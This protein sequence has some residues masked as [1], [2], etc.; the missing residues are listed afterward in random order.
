MIPAFYNEIYDAEQEERREELARERRTLRNESNP[1]ELPDEEFRKMYRLTKELAQNLIAEL[2]PHMNHGQRNTRLPIDLRV[3]AALRFF[4]HG[5]YQKCIGANQ[6]VYVAQ[7]TMSDIIREVCNAIEDIAH[8][9]IKFPTNA[10]DIGIKKQAFWN[11]FNFPGI[12]GCVDGTHV[13]IVK[14]N[15]DEHLYLN[16]KG[17][18]S[19]NVQIICDADLVILSLN[20]NF[21]GATH[22][23]F[24]WRNSAAK[25]FLEENYQNGDHN[26]WLL[27]DSGYPQQPWLM[28]PIRNAPRNS[29]ESRYNGA[30]VSARC[31]VERCIGK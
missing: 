2:E 14:P 27:G 6:N 18:H 23:S 29:P 30:L 10:E 13:A 12:I 3:L 20:A 17:Y 25:N 19:K 28:T 31:T 21:G 11:A 26:T 8:R 15:E 24:I 22:D 16:R 9:Y 5:S 7:Q 4:A 1:F